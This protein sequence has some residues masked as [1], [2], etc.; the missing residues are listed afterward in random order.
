MRRVQPIGHRVE[1]DVGADAEI[2]RRGLDQVADE[3]AGEGTE[4]VDE[5]ARVRCV[6]DGREE[7]VLS[8]DLQ[9]FRAPIREGPALPSGAVGFSDADARCMNDTGPSVA[10]A[11]TRVDVILTPNVN[12]SGAY[13]TFSLTLSVSQQNCEFP[14]TPGATG[15]LTLSGQADGSNM[16]ATIVERGTTRSYGGSMR[17]DGSFSG[18]G[19]GFIAG[20]LDELL[21]SGP[22]VDM[23]DYTGTLQGR[24]TGGSVSG[25]ETI[26]FAAPCPGKTLVIAFGGKR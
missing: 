10:S 14:I 21:I 8:F 25:S 17:Q 12:V 20:L 9:H 4:R 19:G 24:V 22:A 18:S 7:Q 3:A 11:S 1:R 26:N 5:L 6:H 15:T 2:D 23:H 16:T 13:G